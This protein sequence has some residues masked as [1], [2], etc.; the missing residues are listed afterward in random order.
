M[1]KQNDSDHSTGPSTSQILK[2][3]VAATGSF[4]FYYSLKHSKL[5]IKEIE[6]E[7]KGDQLIHI[8]SLS[9]TQIP[10]QNNLTLT[11]E[12]STVSL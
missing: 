7:V 4:I 5:E 10:Q 1:L 6:E 2:C 3:P 9:H 8:H 12:S 11:I